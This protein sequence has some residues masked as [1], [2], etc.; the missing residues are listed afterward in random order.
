MPSCV[1]SRSW[2]QPPCL[3]VSPLGSLIT[4]PVDLPPQGI[5]GTRFL[6]LRGLWANPQGQAPRKGVLWG[7]G[8]TSSCKVEI[9]FEG[10]ACLQVQAPHR[11]SM[12]TQPPLH[13]SI[14]LPT[15]PPLFIASLCPQ[16]L[17]NSH[18]LG[19]HL[20]L[21]FPFFVILKSKKASL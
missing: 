1:V 15:P 9:H 19:T 2:A 17:F 11:V 16:S 4:C 10:A 6:R 3:S 12:A 21:S 20:L 14:S 7:E 13:L 18:S 5:A 8:H